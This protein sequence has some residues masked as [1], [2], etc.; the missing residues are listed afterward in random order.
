MNLNEPRFVDFVYLREPKAYIM[1]YFPF[2]RKVQKNP[3][4]TE[5]V[6]ENPKTTTEQLSL[7]EFYLQNQH[8][9]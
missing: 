8:M 9:D 1:G 4:T 6:E 7:Q 2:W 3:K 5:N